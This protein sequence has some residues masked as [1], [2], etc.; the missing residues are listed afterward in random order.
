MWKGKEANRWES[1]SRI[2]LGMVE[3][4]GERERTEVRFLCIVFGIYMGGCSMD[5]VFSPC[6]IGMEVYVCT[7]LK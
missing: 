1:K 5:L 6:M 3:L 4:G 7:R 2:V